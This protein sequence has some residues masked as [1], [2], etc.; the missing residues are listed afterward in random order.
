[1]RPIHTLATHAL[2][3]GKSIRWVADQLGH[4]DPAL[5]PRVYSHVLRDDEVDLSFADFA[6]A[7]TGSKS[8]SG[9]RLRR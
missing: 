7:E 2:D 1:M 9:S 5:T 3:S 4:A 6:A 8:L